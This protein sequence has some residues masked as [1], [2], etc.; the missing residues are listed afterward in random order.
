MGRLAFCVVLCG[1]SA[2]CASTRPAC[3]QDEVQAGLRDVYNQYLVDNL[4]KPFM[5]LEAS[6]AGIQAFD[7]EPQTLS[8]MIQNLGHESLTTTLRCAQGPQEPAPAPPPQ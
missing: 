4:C 6:L 3:Q 2:G 8:P 1:M 7:S 5:P